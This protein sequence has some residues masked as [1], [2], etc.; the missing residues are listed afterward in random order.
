MGTK[1]N[2]RQPGTHPD[3]DNTLGILAAY[4]CE[5]AANGALRNRK[6]V[7]LL[8]DIF[9]PSMYAKGKKS[10]DRTSMAVVEIRRQGAVRSPLGIIVSPPVE[11]ITQELQASRWSSP[12]SPPACFM[13][14]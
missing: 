3:R 5:V 8:A 2:S 1:E 10:V 14:E 7:K 6:M 11:H 4:D 13:T 12:H 9:F